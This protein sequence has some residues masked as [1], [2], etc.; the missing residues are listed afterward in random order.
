MTYNSKSKS[1]YVGLISTTV[2]PVRLHRLF[3][4][5]LRIQKHLSITQHAYPFIE[6]A[7]CVVTVKRDIVHWYSHIISVV[8]SVQMDIRIGGK[9]SWL[10][11]CLL[12]Y[13]IYSLALVLHLPAFMVWF[14]SQF[15]FVPAFIRIVLLV[16]KHE[17]PSSSKS[18][19][20]F[21]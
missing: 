20:C 17:I 18:R 3:K 11:L 6:L 10:D 9:F 19:L 21:L 14:G 12:Q 8:W 1:T 7:Y 15:V 16:F 5:Y 4:S 2:E 13:S